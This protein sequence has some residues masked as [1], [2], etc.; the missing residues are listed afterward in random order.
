MQTVINK[1][2]KFINCNENN[3]ETLEELH[4][5]YNFTPL[6]ISI[7]QR[8]K[9]IWEAGKATKPEHYNNLTINYE[10]EHTWFPKSTKVINRGTHEAIITRQQ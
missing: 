3:K 2:L 4:R 1:A 9:K 8:A 10:R 5:K 7:D 6:N